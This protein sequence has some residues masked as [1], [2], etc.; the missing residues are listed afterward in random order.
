MI[1]IFE[2]FNQLLNESASE[3]QVLKA[4]RGKNL[5][6]ITYR[7][8]VPGYPIESG[9]R[10]CVILAYGIGRY[11]DMPCIR[12][13]QTNPRISA[14]KV[15]D[16]KIL[17]LKDIETFRILPNIVKEAPPLFNPNEDR[18]MKETI[19]VARWKKFVPQAKYRKKKIE[20][21]LYKTDTERNLQQ[22]KQVQKIDVTGHSK[23]QAERFKEVKSISNKALALWKK[24]ERTGDRKNAEIAKQKYLEIQRLANQYLSGYKKEKQ[25]LQKPVNTLY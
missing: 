10:Y 16:Y 6:F 13:F 3:G 4:L 5:C 15:S 9:S 20:P 11:E 22:N 17:Y 24:I 12:V 7:T 21:E 19:E 2:I 1:N 25:A 8:N 18:W 23:T 14:G